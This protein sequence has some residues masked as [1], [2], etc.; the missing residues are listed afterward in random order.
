MYLWV[1]KVLW[2]HSN[3]CIHALCDSCNSIFTC[4]ISNACC[5]MVIRS[6]TL[7]RFISRENPL[8]WMQ[9]HKAKQYH[10]EIAS[11]NPLT[12]FLKDIFWVHHCL[13][14]LSLDPKEH[15][16]PYYATTWTN[17]LWWEQ[18]RRPPHRTAGMVCHNWWGWQPLEMARAVDA[19][20]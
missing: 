18:L 19:G 16:S 13:S 7:F 12:F 17:Q 6:Y 3:T 10:Q 15:L 2:L 20:L 5:Y 14:T 9:C 1:E 8:L 11:V 4:Y